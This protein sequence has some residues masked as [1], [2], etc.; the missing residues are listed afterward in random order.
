M[1]KMFMFYED[2]LLLMESDLHR[3]QNLLQYGSIDYEAY[4][5]KLDRYAENKSILSFKFPPSNGAVIC[6]LE[7]IKG[8]WIEARVHTTCNQLNRLTKLISLPN[9]RISYGFKDMA[10]DSDIPIFS[11]HKKVDYKG[12]IL[13]PDFEIYEQNYYCM[14]LYKD[15]MNFHDKSNKAI[16]VGSTTG[17]N[18]NEDRG[19]QNTIENIASDPSVRIDAAMYF[20]GNE[21]I[22]F[23][24]PA[25][26]QCDSKETEDYLRKFSFASP[27]RV[28]WHEQFKHKFIIS[29][30]GN[31][32]TLT[33]VA[34]TLLSNS[35]LLKYNSN[36]I[37]YY[38]RVLRPHVNFIPIKS[39]KEIEDAVNASSGNVDFYE[40]ISREASKDF[41][42]LL[43]RANVDRYYAA[44]LNEFYAI[45]FGKNDTYL[46]NRKKLEQVAHLDIDAHFS[47]VG[48]VAFWPCQEVSDPS[49]N[50]IEGLTIYPASSLF[51]WRDISY[52]V[53]YEDGTASEM[54]LG[55]HFAGSK[56]QARKIVGFRLVAKSEEQ[57]NL[58]YSGEFADGS[59]QRVL[60]GIWLQHDKSPL[61]KITFEI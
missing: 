49:G 2:F 38:H 45:F 4:C 1:K 53:A 17:S 27:A 28:E 60:N 12:I 47:N 51:D 55:G 18:A 48:D 14:D 35:V 46:A 52:Q 24:L 37:A 15:A 19:V 56:S 41:S 54:V 33:R 57:F 8:D 26:V 20:N 42:L 25:I 23:K 44:V 5:N 50:F 22:I 29:V 61:K 58:S 9:L 13:V 59:A 40:K 30:D 43:K 7:Q 34:A 21:N 16:F 3:A 32:P 11:Y 36:W 39:H 6:D 10:G 31:G